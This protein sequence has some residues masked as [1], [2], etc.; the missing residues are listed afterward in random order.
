MPYSFPALMDLDIAVNRQLHGNKS[1]L[2]PKLRALADE[3]PTIPEYFDFMDIR[4]P[5][6]RYVHDKLRGILDD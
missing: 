2:S 6:D 5:A 3:V 4:K 1:A